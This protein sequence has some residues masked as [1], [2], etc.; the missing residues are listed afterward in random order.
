MTCKEV[1]TF[2]STGSL[3]EGAWRM[4]LA[5]R[6]H[7]SMCRHC[8]ALKRQL[9]ALAKTARSLSASLDAELPKNFEA[10]LSES[11][12]RRPSS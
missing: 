8:R 5:V 12:K 2:M 6:M 9:D 11:L 1:S 7:L 4:R 10:T 3:D